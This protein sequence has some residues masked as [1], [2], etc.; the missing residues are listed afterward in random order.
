MKL[1]VSA[2]N[3]TIVV[4]EYKYL[5]AQSNRVGYPI[6]L[7]AIMPVKYF[8]TKPPISILGMITGNPMMVMML[9]MGIVVVFFP[10]MMAGMSPEDLAEMK[11]AS[12]QQGDPMKELTKLMGGKV[13]SK[14]E[15]EDD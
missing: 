12:A 9:I 8:Q 13:E 3:G 7:T 2:E 14:E 11:K 6:V 15:D 4:N 10:K 5:G 1:K